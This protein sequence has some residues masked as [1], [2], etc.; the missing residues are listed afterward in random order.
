M[1]Q[2]DVGGKFCGK[3][4]REA[5][6]GRYH[7]SQARLHV[8]LPVGLSREAEKGSLVRCWSTRPA[9]SAVDSVWM[10]P[11]SYT[12]QPRQQ[13]YATLVGMGCRPH[14]YEAELKLGFSLCWLRLA[15]PL[16]GAASQ[17]TLPSSGSCNI[18]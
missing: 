6:T 12:R 16:P 11:C 2:R 4:L 5:Y 7:Q 9:L 13:A 3:P 15:V 10:E 18:K 14:L 8:K 17:P 1:S